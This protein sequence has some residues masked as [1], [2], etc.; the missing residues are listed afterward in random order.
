MCDGVGGIAPCGRQH[1]LLHW[2]GPTAQ[3]EDVESKLPPK[4][5]V[6]VKVP[7]SP[8]QSTIYQWIK[9]SGERRVVCVVVVVVVVCVCVVVVVVCVC[10]GGGRAG[11]GGGHSCRPG[12]IGLPAA[13]HALPRAS[14]VAQLSPRK[15]R[16]HQR[17][18]TA[19][20]T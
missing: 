2:P 7:M 20:H 3:V 4:I 6:V 9:A 1:V 8:Y 16:H 13:L 17:P 18:H 12:S 14:H 10:E 5:P 19:K 15:P 11:G